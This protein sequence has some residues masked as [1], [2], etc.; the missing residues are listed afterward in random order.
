MRA[1]GGQLQPLG[2]MHRDE[3][4]RDQQGER[5]WSRL[6]ADGGGRAARAA[7]RA[8][9]GSDNEAERRANTRAARRARTHTRFLLLHTCSSSCLLSV[10]SAGGAAGRWGRLLLPAELSLIDCATGRVIRVDGRG[11]RHAGAP[12]E[13]VAKRPPARSRPTGPTPPSP[14]PPARHTRAARLPRARR[15]RCGERVD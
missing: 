4:A 3:R 13:P 7:N 5:S 6:V 14:L 10:W 1:A 9:A 11:E 2:G 8:T 15:T 12:S